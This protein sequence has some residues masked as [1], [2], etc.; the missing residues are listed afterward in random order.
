[1]VNKMNLFSYIFDKGNGYLIKIL[2]QSWLCI[3][4]H[5]YAIARNASSLYPHGDPAAA[6]LDR[7]SGV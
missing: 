6:P 4:V 7:L 5:L 2:V 3:R 1:M